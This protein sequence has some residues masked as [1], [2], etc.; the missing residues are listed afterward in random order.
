MKDVKFKINFS[1]FTFLLIGFIYGYIVADADKSN[2]SD[3]PSYVPA[4]LVNTLFLIFLWKK[5]LYHRKD[6]K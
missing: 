3:I 2:W 4:V 1:I 6:K 5:Y